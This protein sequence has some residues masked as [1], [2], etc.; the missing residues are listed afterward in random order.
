MPHSFILVFFTDVLTFHGFGFDPNYYKASD[1]WVRHV[2]IMI[3]YG[4]ISSLTII[5]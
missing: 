1:L 5:S 4:T 3:L 2:K